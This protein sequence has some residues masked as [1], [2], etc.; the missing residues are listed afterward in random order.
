MELVFA[1]KELR[2]YESFLSLKKPRPWL[3][4][5]LHGGWKMKDN[6]KF[7]DVRIYKRYV[8]EGEITLKDY[9]KHVKSLPDVSDKATFLIIDE[10]EGAGEQEE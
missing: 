3:Q 6:E 5:S 7:F 9:E 10:E 4:S 1:R 2:A 8:K